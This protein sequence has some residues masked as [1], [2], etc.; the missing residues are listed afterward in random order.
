[1]THPDT[2]RLIARVE[3]LTGYPVAVETGAGFYEQAQMMSAR[4]GAPV[5]LIR[6]NERLR[7]QADYVVAAQC[8]M[9]LVMWSDPSRVF[10]MAF[11]DDACSALA[12]EWAGRRQLATLPGDQAMRTARFYVEGLLKQ[13]NSMP[14]EIRVANFCHQ[15]CPDLRPMQVA[16]FEAQLR[17]LSSVFAPQVRER[18]PEDVFDRNVSMNAALAGNWARLSGNRIALLPYESL[19][20][21]AAGER[22]LEA[23]D[24]LPGMTAESHMGTVDA[25]AR[26]LAMDTL[27]SWEFSD[28]R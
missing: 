1:M 8:G 16:L 5:H 21:A 28:R 15:E 7:D 13:L 20:Y 22:L 11:D 2:Q 17:E 14:L 12:A 19:G 6:V 9:L 27:Y 3:E 10:G 25:W 24:S 26:Q 18:A 4:P 23:L